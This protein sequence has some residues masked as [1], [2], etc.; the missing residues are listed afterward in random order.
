MEVKLVDYH[1][2]CDY[3]LDA[4]GTVEKYCARALELGFT[5]ICF[6]PHYEIDPL[7]QEMARAKG[8]KMPMTSDWLN[9]YLS[10]LNA[11]KRIYRNKRLTIRAGIEVG[12]QPEIE[13]EI[14]RKLA[15]YSFDFVL[16]SVHCLDHIDISDPKES[17]EYFKNRSAVQ[18]IKSYYYALQKAVDSQLFDS[19][20]HLDVYKMYGADYYG[21]EVL[22]MHRNY[23]EPILESM[24]ENWVGLEINTRCLRLGLGETSPSFDILTKAKQKGIRI[25]TVG[26]DCHRVEELGAGIVEAYR[27]ALKAGFNE[28]SKFA[29]RRRTSFRLR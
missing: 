13:R 7:R 24:S 6:T 19:I 9:T 26:S 15:E 28:I 12:Y 29:K 2:H 5:E 14:R 20:G 11:A 22:S 1:V 3:S 10:E 16:G 8:K 27:L 23:V 21:Q 18:A 17:I 4:E 25:I